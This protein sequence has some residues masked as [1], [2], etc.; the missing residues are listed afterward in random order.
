MR[1]LPPCYNKAL[2]LLSR[3]SHFRQELKYKLLRRGY[4]EEEV[5]EVLDRLIEKRF[6]DDRATAFEF[7]RSRVAREPL[8]RARLLAELA[9]RGVESDLAN[10]V[11]SE[12]CPDDDRAPAL[13]AAKR[14]RSKRPRGDS[15]ALA[16]Y[17]SRRGFR[18][19]AIYEA[20]EQTS[21]DFLDDDP[22]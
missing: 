16:R 3:R 17:L 9:K 11:A 21:Q 22:H 13:E 1:E 15:A 6:L 8:G 19:S 7:A 5:E 2:D 12:I 20:L 10:E 18:S 14:W 4:E